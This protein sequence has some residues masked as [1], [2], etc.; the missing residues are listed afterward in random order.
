MS[1]TTSRPPRGFAVSLIIFFCFLAGA[2]FA[3]HRL[4]ASGRADCRRAVRDVRLRAGAYSLAMLMD[5]MRD[6]ML[7]SVV[8]SIRRSY[9][10]NVMRFGLHPRDMQRW[11][12]FSLQLAEELRTV[13]L[14]EVRVRALVLSDG[15]LTVVISEDEAAAP[16]RP[17]LSATISPR[18]SDPTD[19]AP[20]ARVQT[21]VHA[22][23]LVHGP[24]TAT[25]LRAPPTSAWQL[26]VAGM[27]AVRLNAEVLVGRA[28]DSHVRLLD[29]TVSAQ[30]AR[31]ALLDDAV[32]VV[33]LKSSNGTFVNGRRVEMSTLRSGDELRFG[34]RIAATIRRLG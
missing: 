29:G 34:S 19:V 8:P 6:D 33:D 25:V 17:I 11:G 1:A 2:W 18:R 12:Q 32:T 20:I 4:P 23:D 24:T 27:P 10:P 5:R 13:M 28:R 7:N 22:P 14:E 3:W 31:L 15:R 26:E 9:M 21:E 30:H 16:G